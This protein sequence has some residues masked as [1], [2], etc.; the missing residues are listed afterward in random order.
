MEDMEMVLC[1]KFLR[2]IKYQGVVLVD[3]VGISGEIFVRGMARI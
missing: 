1:I 2:A 3:H